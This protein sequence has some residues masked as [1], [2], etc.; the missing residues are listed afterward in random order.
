MRASIDLKDWNPIP[1]GSYRAGQMEAIDAMITNFENGVKEQTYRAPTAAGKTLGLITVGNILNKHYGLRKILFTSPQVS[2][3]E[4]GNLFGIKKLVGKANYPCLGMK[5][6]TA[7]DCPFGGKKKLWAVCDEC[8]YLLAKEEFNEV[9]FGATT[10]ARYMVDPNIRDATSVLVV[11]ESTNLLKDVI[12]QA[13]L[14][15]P[16]NVKKDTDL[17]GRQAGL[18]KYKA[19]LKA[20]LESAEFLLRSIV[21]RISETDNPSDS[22]IMEMRSAR[23]KV[24]GAAAKLGSCEKAI[25]YINK[26]VPNAIVSEWLKKEERE[27]LKKYYKTWDEVPKQKHVFRLVDPRLPYKE[28]VGGLQCV[29]LASGTPTTQYL[30][31]ETMYNYN[32]DETKATHKYVTTQ[33]PIDPARRP[34]Y[35][36]PVGPMS[37]G[38]TRKNNAP[39]MAA[40]LLKLFNDYGS[41]MLVH[42]GNYN[43]AE[44]VG[45]AL[46]GKTENLIVQ[47]QN[48][49]TKDMK[50]WL[51][52]DGNIFL[53]VSYEEGVDCAGE[54]FPRQAI[55]Q[56]PF[57]AKD[58]W[59][60]Q[61]QIDLDPYEKLYNETVAVKIMQA[62]GRV[63]RGPQDY[64][65]TYILD[66]NFGWFYSKY[67][68]MFYNWFGAALQK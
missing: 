34:I 66:S 40:K 31:D 1:G 41:N 47:T 43:T 52:H 57:P 27:K 2:L 3:I 20:K 63:C 28:F 9:D 67:N 35:Y 26:N 61:R 37:A 16:E 14:P 25:Y 24:N 12:G 30:T 42:C 10:L 19:V 65:E 11:D 21:D 60:K 50:N 48:T 7:D 45:E 29:I 36:E 51:A 55:I 58:E 5:N 4:E 15:L 46:E 68:Y 17:L 22:L 18:E 64:G 56:V 44:L 53:S 49:R 8:P 59:W 33:H 54:R 39:K 38:E 23:R 32:M 62:C 6:C 13:E